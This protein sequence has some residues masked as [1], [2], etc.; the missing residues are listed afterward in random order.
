VSFADGVLVP[1]PAAVLVP[2]PA[3]E[4]T[5]VPDE[6]I[7][8][9]GGTGF[10]GKH[11]VSA[12][13]AS[14]KEATV[15]TRTPKNDEVAWTPTEDGAWTKIIDGAEAVVHL[16]GASVADE[17][18]TDARK[19]EISDS[20]VRSTAILAEAIKASKNRPRVMVSASAVGYYGFRDE[21]CDES[22]AHGEDFLARVCVDWEAAADAARSVTRVVHPRIGIVLGDQGALPKMLGP[23]KAFVG[24][25]LGTGRQVLSWIHIADAV[26]ALVFLLDNEKLSGPVNVVAPQPVSQRVMAAEIGKKIGRPSLIPTPAFA[27]AIVLGRERAQMV[28]SGQRVTPKKLND[29]N[30]RFDFATLNNALA[31]LL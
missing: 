28:L 23:I 29:A 31:D 15:L 27:L 5:R 16:A 13:R 2:P 30:F 7:L 8:V 11:L 21:P 6:M 3:A 20:R 18:W 19:K 10:V 25:P 14:K 22:A 12:L 26:R 4:T 9:T 24:G 1:P 17:R